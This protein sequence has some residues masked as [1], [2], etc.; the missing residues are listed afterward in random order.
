METTLSPN[1]FAERAT[2]ART[3]AT[4]RSINA[5][6]LHRRTPGGFA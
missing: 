2:H 4:F 6:Q 3:P 1:L 5:G